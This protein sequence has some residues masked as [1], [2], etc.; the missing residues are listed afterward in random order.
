[1]LSQALAYG[2][3][4]RPQN[5]HSAQK[6]P[7]GRTFVEAGFGM[8][9]VLHASWAPG[10]APRSSIIWERTAAAVL[11]S[12]VERRKGRRGR[13]EPVCRRAAEGRGR[14][15]ELLVLR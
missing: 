1:M 10:M 8:S 2:I 5:L 13:V 12:G 9:A 14:A 6:M 4:A 7:T 3:R 11:A 15:F